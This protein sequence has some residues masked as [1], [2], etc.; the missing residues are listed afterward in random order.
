MVWTN[1]EHIQLLYNAN[2]IATALSFGGSIFMIYHCLRTPQPRTVTVTLILSI[3]VADFLYSISNL[4]SAFQDAGPKVSPLCYAEAA[5]RAFSYV[6]SIF[7][8]SCLG[9][10]CYKTVVKG[11]D[12]NQDAFFKRS[13]IVGVIYCTAQTLL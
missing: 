13:L 7:F 4:M 1:G 12:F 10:L 11:L 3:G 5:L 2:N 9:I 8:A 6:L